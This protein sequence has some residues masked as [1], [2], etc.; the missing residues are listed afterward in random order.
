VAEAIKL[1]HGFVEIAWAKEAIADGRL[2]AA[3]KTLADVRHRLTRVGTP[4]GGAPALSDR[5]DDIRSTLR[6]LRPILAATDAAL[7]S[8]RG[9]K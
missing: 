6:I 8:R 9:V 5:S 3:A 4:S 1:T 7:I 2:D